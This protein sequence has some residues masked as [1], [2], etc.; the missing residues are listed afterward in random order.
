MDQTFDAN[1]YQQIVQKGLMLHLDLEPKPGQL[2]L[3]VQDG[4]TGTGGNHQRDGPLVW[5]ENSLGLKT[6]DD[7]SCRRVKGN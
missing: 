3:A 1:T 6:G 4:R 5:L 2:R 7:I